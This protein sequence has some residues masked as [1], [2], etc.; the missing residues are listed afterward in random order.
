MQSFLLEL[1]GDCAFV[2]R[3]KRLRIGDQWFRIDLL[4]FHRRL[5]CLVIVELKRGELTAGD[6]GQINMYCNNARAHWMVEGENPPVG[7]VLCTEKDA[8]LAQYAFGG[9]ESK[10]LTA[11]YRTILPSEQELAMELARAK[12]EIRRR[13]LPAPTKSSKK[14][15]GWRAGEPMPSWNGAALDDQLLR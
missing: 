14:P 11:E 5:R 2:G 15:G 12:A 1:G 8:A 6:A 3:Q 9:L 10:V 4:F 13:Q 7:L